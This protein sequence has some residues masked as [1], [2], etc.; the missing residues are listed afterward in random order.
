M[1]LAKILSYTVN[2]LIFICIFSFVGPERMVDVVDSTT[3]EALTMSLG[4]FCDYYQKTERG[5]GGGRELKRIL[6]VISL[7]ISHTPLDPLVEAP[8]AVSVS[9]DYHVTCRVVR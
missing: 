3:Q 4:D 6:N 5:G 7:E 2:V 9:R 8:Q 1:I